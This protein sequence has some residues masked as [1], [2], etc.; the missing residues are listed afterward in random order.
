METLLALL[1]VYVFVLGLGKFYGQCCRVWAW[2]RDRVM[3]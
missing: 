3:L 1:S 2:V